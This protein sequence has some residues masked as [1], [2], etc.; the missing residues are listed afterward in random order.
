MNGFGDL[1]LLNSSDGAIPPGPGRLAALVG[2]PRFR[3]DALGGFRFGWS[4]YGD[5]YH[6]T[7]GWR[8]LWVCSHPDLVREV[9]VEGRDRWR[10]I[11]TNGGGR[12]MGL[13][14]ALGD[15]L[16]TTDGPDWQWRRRIVNPAFHRQR[17]DGMVEE[18][19]ACGEEMLDRLSMAAAGR[20][21]VDLLLEMKRVTQNIISRT[22]FSTEIAE[23]ADRVGEAVDV[24]LQYV[25]KRSRAIVSVPT[26][27]PTASARRF[28]RAMA[29]LDD[30]IYRI[31]EQRRS[32]G[33]SGDDLLGMLLDAVDEE[34]GKKLSDTQIRNEVAT[35]YGAGHET[36]ANALTWTWHELMRSPDVLCRLQSEVDQV[37]GPDLGRLEYTKGVLEE[38]LRFRPP[39]PVNG[40]VATDATTLGGY[41]VEPGAIAL[42]IV[43]NIHRH[44]DFW[45]SPDNFHPDHFTAE[46]KKA[47]DR[48]AWVPF[49][50]GPHLCIGNNFAMIEGT[51]LLAQMAR[52]LTFEPAVP[53]PRSSSLA[54]TLKPRNGLPVRVHRR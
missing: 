9:L 11:D 33:E 24:A 45:D 40:R 22:M 39:V 41:R 20:E 17:I 43:N 19:V 3:S 15:G 37:A 2:I 10:R 23:D 42:L 29:D 46:A 30:V 14:L 16:L 26:W 50:A 13:G 34:T 38:V 53:L 44:P 5:L 12:E 35:V 8:D 47:R 6:V 1:G 51:I 31:I 48:H 18:M 28:G 52:H 27:I 32:S 36:T 54:V 21:P 7:M 49:G 4:K 25:A